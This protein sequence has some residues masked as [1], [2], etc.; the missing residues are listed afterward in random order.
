MGKAIEMKKAQSI[1]E[2]VIMLSVIVGAIILG[3]GGFGTKIQ[4][5]R[6]ALGDRAG[7]AYGLEASLPPLPQTSTTDPT[8]PTDPPEPPVSTGQV[9]IPTSVKL[10]PGELEMLDAAGILQSSRNDYDPPSGTILR[11]GLSAAQNKVIDDIQRAVNKR[12]GVTG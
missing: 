1:L 7:R 12:Y 11:V 10:L 6:I 3:S 4:T 8:D 2:Y 9:F 5:G